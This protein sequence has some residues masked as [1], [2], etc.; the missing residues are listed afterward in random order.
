[1]KHNERA[2]VA[3]LVFVFKMNCGGGGLRPPACGL[4]PVA[5][6][7]LPSGG[8]CGGGLRQRPAVAACG[9]ALQRGGIHN[10]YFRNFTNQY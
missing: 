9:A 3:Q 4:R 10:R 1:M 2:R 5:A 8:G 7:R 6:L